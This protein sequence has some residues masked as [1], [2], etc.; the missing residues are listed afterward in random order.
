MREP[1]N[2]VFG[3]GLSRTGTRSLAVAL[4]RLGFAAVH[5]PSDPVTFDQLTRGDLRLRILERFDAVT[6]TPVVPYYAQL[7]A[8][9]PGSRFILT[10]RD[11]EAWLSSCERLWRHTA[12]VQ[13][14]PFHRFINTAVYGTWDFAAERFAYVEARHR[15]EVH[16]HFAGRPGALLELDLTAGAGWG[17]LCAFLERP[18]PAE[19]FPHEDLLRPR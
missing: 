4:Q 14:R 7:D 18:V 10:V 19:P 6:D 15:A 17:P 13:A 5:F 1:V 11:R 2:K 12:A 16:R 8:L 9:F 3:I